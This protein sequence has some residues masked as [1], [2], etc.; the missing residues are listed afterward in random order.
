METG[1]DQ[2]RGCGD[3]F[4]LDGFVGY[5]VSADEQAVAVDTVGGAG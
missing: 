3:D 5:P 1:A 2:T 4:V